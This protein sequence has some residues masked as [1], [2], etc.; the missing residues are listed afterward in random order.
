[1]LRESGVERLTSTLPHNTSISNLHVGFNNIGD[2]GANAIFQANL[3][4]TVLQTLKLGGNLIA[5]QGLALVPA[6]LESMSNLVVLHLNN[7]MIGDV[8]ARYLAQGLA[9]SDCLQVLNLNGNR[10]RDPGLEIMSHAL[11]GGAGTRAQLIRIFGNHPR[12]CS[13]HRP[14]APN[15]SLKALHLASNWLRDPGADRIA[16][17]LEGNWNLTNVELA[18]NRIGDE[19]ARALADALRYSMLDPSNNKVPRKICL[20]CNNLSSI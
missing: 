3:S 8:G 20:S 13:G 16:A 1:M 18:S 10:I 11:I 9:L 4:R 17:I 19:G 2:G 12:S 14:W 7:N 5:D 15:T 6:F